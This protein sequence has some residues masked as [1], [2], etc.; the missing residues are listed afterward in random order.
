[1]NL[2]KDNVFKLYLKYFIPTIGAALS[3]AIYILFDTIFIG[4]GV[5]GDGL[6]AL[7]IAIP[8]FGFYSGTGLLIGIGGSTLLSIERGRGHEKRSNKIF[9]LS[10]IM[11]SV[12]SI[13][14][15]IL[16]LLFIDKV[17][18]FLGATEY[19]LPLVKEYLFIIMIGTVAFVMVNVLSPFIRADKAP[20]TAMAAV[21]IG[22]F[23]NIALDYIF[24][25]PLN[26]GMKGAAIAT[27]ISS[28]LSLLVLSI[29]FIGK[30][31]TLRFEDNFFRVST[32][33]RIIKCGLPSFFSEISTG[34]VIF[35]FNLQIMRLLGEDGVTAYSIISNTAIII[36]A[37][38]NGICQ[39]IQPLISVNI[40]AGEKERV[41]CF[42]KIAIVTAIILGILSYIICI[43]F[44]EE[45]VRIFVKP[46]DKVLSI[47]VNSINIY[48]VAFV[49]TG[50]NM[51]LGA[52][53][54]SVEEAKY[55]FIIA[56]CRGL[57]LVSVAVIILPIFMG[58][59]GVWVSVPVAEAIT[60][61]IGIML[62]LKMR[63]RKI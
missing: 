36:I 10:I 21:I 37:V 46:T 4:Q 31:N 63:T 27:V 7:N 43:V 40:G 28:T 59:N 51:V 23:T 35:I 52:F 38:F 45:I 34:L 19:I 62:T 12:I 39:T 58:I 48:A 11:G 60:F 41:E 14:Y 50:V 13:L 33:I 32:A 30:S 25:F 49:V 47:A 57:L 15:M 29:H 56:I 5:G 8:I 2:L 61:I 26:M 16:G 9:T 17:A 54:Q 20:K 55:S 22:G 24:V 3:S 44:P 6:A 1:M 42:K 53:F 18:Y